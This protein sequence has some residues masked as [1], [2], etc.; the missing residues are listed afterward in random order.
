MNDFVGGRVNHSRFR[1][2]RRS[3]SSRSRLS[4]GVLTFAPP[5]DTC[6]W[7]GFYMIRV[8]V[9]KSKGYDYEV[10]LALR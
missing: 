2:R 7:L 9:L 8:G 4:R 10:G 5:P 3:H 1:F 6:P